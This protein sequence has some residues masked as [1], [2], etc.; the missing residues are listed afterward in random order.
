M[1]ESDRWATMSKVYYTPACEELEERRR[2]LVPIAK[3]Q[4]RLRRAA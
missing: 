3:E 2:E 4:Q 1:E